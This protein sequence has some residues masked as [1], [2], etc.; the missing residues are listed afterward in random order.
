MPLLSPQQPR[1]PPLLLLAPPPPLPCYVRRESPLLILDG[2]VAG[3]FA[4]CIATLHPEL[5]QQESECVATEADAVT[6][7]THGILLFLSAGAQAAAAAVA[8]FAP[9]AWRQ[10]HVATAFAIF[11]N[12]VGILA[13]SAPPPCYYIESQQAPSG[14]RASLCT[15]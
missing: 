11:A 8:A 9:D 3:A 15:Q 4:L 13:S 1:N 7:R 6:M 12:G 2:L 10:L 14:R 5:K